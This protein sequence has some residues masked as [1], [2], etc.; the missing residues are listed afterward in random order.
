[1]SVV[2]GLVPSIISSCIPNGPDSR[3]ALEEGVYK[4]AMFMFERIGVFGPITSA[5]ALAFNRHT[6]LPEGG[7][8]VF[9]P[10]P[11]M[12]DE[13]DSEE[14]YEPLSSQQLVDDEGDAQLG[15]D[16]GV[17]YQNPILAPIPL[18]SGPEDLEFGATP[19]EPDD[20]DEQLLSS[21]W[22]G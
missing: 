9:A 5:V 13:M 16:L 2:A 20:P 19:Q 18:D 1:M 6:D 3:A 11:P 22:P 12:P 14:E 15:P 8:L 4:V 21:Y 17:E 7:N 10:M